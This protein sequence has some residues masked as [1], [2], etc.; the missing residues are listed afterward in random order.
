MQGEILDR[1]HQ[2]RA[3]ST[4]RYSGALDCL[5]RPAILE[6][7]LVA[8]SEEEMTL[9]FDLAIPARLWQMCG[10]AFHLTALGG[11]TSH[12]TD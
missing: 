2:L 6:Q 8:E 5:A 1:F 3:I 7:A 4:C 12:W 9:L 11:S 10:R